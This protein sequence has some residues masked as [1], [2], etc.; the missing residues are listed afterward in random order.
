MGAGRKPLETLEDVV[1]EAYRVFKYPVP[2]KHGVCENCCMN[3]KIEKDFLKVPIREMPINYLESWF[4]GAVDPDIGLDP[5]IG[6]YLLPRVLEAIAAGDEPARVGIEVTL[7]SFPIGDPTQ[8]TG[9]QRHVLARFHTLFLNRQKTSKTDALD[10]II[11]MF[12]LAGLAPETTIAAVEAW[13]NA[14]LTN[15]LWYDW[16]AHGYPEIWSSAFWDGGSDKLIYDWYRSERLYDRLTEYGL[17]DDTSPEMVQK[18]SDLTA[19]IRSTGD[20]S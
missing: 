9:A 16:C 2:E 19:L 18:A 6:G 11:C 17:A 10:D 7:R 5:Q 1:E 14:D 4:D 8:W 15:K 20:F 3:P 13:S 12:D